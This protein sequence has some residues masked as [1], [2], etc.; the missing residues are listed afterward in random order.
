MVLSKLPL[1]MNFPSGEKETDLTSA[2]CPLNDDLTSPVTAS[3]RWILPLPHPAAIKLS[4]GEK[5]TL[6]TPYLPASTVRG[7]PTGAPVAAFQIRT[8]LSSLQDA[9]HLPHG[10]KA[11]EFT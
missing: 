3:T 6:R 11:T 10:E 5:E 4:L 8:V 7:D 9:I 1:A 2:L